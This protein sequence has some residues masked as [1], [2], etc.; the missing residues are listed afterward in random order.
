MARND[1]NGMGMGLRTYGTSPF[2]FE[3][4][5]WTD[6]TSSAV[7]FPPSH[8]SALVMT[9]LQTRCHGCNRGFTHRGLTLHLSKTRDI[10]CRK[11]FIALQDPA[12]SMSI[13]YMASPLPLDL[14]QVSGSVGPGASLD[15]G[16]PGA[17]LG[18][19]GPCDN[20]GENNI[21]G[22]F[23]MQPLEGKS[24]TVCHVNQ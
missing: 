22:D 16:G 2:Y 14:P 12:V 24:A 15:G 5:L 19:D 21:D 6:G 11:I 7:F 18:V 20:W 9:T 10:R 8:A 23:M 13:P 4:S 3:S 17:S 1:R